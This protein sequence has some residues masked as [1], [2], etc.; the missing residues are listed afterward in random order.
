MSICY[1]LFSKKLNRFYVGSTIEKA[2]DRLEKHLS[3][4]Y[5][6]FHFTHS[7]NDWSAFLSIQ[8]KNINQ[9]RKIETHIKKMKSKKY[10]QNLKKYS[11]LIEKLL[12]KYS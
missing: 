2:E 10:I 7:A 3:K 8:C 12:N 5:D 4:F 9:A 6:G 11:E 1:I